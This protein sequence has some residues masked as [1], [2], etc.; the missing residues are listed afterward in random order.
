MDFPQSVDP[1][2][3][4]AAVKRVSE[5]KGPEKAWLVSLLG[6][7]VSDDAEVQITLRNPGSPSIPGPQASAA[8]NEIMSRMEAKL[9]DVSAKD[10]EESLDE[11]MSAVRPRYR[12]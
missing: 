2:M 9:H 7:D 4:P 12:P 5:L 6:T 3:S 10:M 1:R 8:L 11:A